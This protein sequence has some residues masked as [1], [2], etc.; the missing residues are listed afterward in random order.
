MEELQSHREN[1]KQM[2]ELQQK[3]SKLSD[4]NFQMQTRVADAYRQQEALGAKIVA[5][6]LELRKKD[7][8]IVELKRQIKELTLQMKTLKVCFV[9]PFAF[10]FLL[11]VLLPSFFSD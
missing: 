9:S 2:Q 7:A 5:K 3:V 1:S 8:E 11:F 6:D 4:F 10:F